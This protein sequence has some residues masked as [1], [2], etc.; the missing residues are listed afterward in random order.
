MA[1]CSMQLLCAI[2]RDLYTG[3]DDFDFDRSLKFQPLF[4][5]CADVSRVRQKNRV[6]RIRLEIG[7]CRAWTGACSILCCCTGI[8]TFKEIGAYKRGDI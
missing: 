4:T 2:V 6:V 5:V 8:E 7:Q 3:T 1:F